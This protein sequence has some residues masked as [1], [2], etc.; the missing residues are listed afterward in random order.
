[1]A[2]FVTLLCASY[3]RTGNL[4]PHI[5]SGLEFNFFGGPALYNCTSTEL[6]IKI[7]DNFVYS[8]PEGQGRRKTSAPGEIGRRSGEEVSRRQRYPPGLRPASDVRPL[9]PPPVPGHVCLFYYFIV[10]L[11]AHTH[12]IWVHGNWLRK[13]ERGDKLDWKPIR[14]QRNQ[15]SWLAFLH[16]KNVFISW[17]GSGLGCPESFR[18]W[19]KAIK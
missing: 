14:H 3:A 1:M 15:I 9:L 17:P 18:N 12:T 2:L 6:C 4:P 7:K 5:R 19:G 10:L 16:L 8:V 11:H 13:G